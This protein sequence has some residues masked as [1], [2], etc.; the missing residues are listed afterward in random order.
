MDLPNSTDIILSPAHNLQLI[1]V[2]NRLCCMRVLCMCVK[3]LT[4]LQILGCELHKNAFVSQ[5]PPRPI[6]DL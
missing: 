4:E 5:A 6:S 1:T 3:L 2:H